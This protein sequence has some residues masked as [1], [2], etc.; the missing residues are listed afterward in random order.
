[1]A[2]K[3]SAGKPLDHSFDNMP[4]KT[5]LGR[6]DPLSGIDQ[7]IVRMVEVLSF[8]DNLCTTR[9]ASIFKPATERFLLHVT[10]TEHDQAN[11]RARQYGNEKRD[12]RPPSHPARR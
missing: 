12:G 5:G 8:E 6:R 11:A 4:F 9:Q 1:M 3:R 7:Q 10:R 2:N